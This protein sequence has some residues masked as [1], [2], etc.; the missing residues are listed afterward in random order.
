MEISAMLNTHIEGSVLLVEDNVRIS[1][2]MA[3]MM[4][5]AG[6]L[7]RCAMDAHEMRELMAISIPDVVLLDLN[8]PGEDG[9]SICRW[10]RSVYPDIGIVMLTARVMS[11]ERSEGY[12]A[13]A[14]VYLTKPTRAEELLAVLRNF[15]RRLKTHA[16]V[17]SAS[18]VGSWVLHVADMRL[19]SPE[20]DHLRLNLKETL[21]LKRLSESSEAVSYQSLLDGILHHGELLAI[22]KVQLEV[23]I[24]RLRTKLASLNDTSIEIKTAHKVGYQL[25]LP[26]IVRSKTK[27]KPGVSQ[28]S[29]LAA[30]SSN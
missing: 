11:S 5:A 16:D 24:S 7:V 1:L 28:G 4:G 20:A 25:S 9:I 29:S 26:L 18:V 22:D 13:G 19:E 23:V 10:L 14:D 30:G 21:V 27:E 3:Q 17:G 8:L 12:L 15:L 6:L 2:E